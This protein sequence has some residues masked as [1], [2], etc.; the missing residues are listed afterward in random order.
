M[1]I[2][3]LKQ[4]HLTARKNKEQVKT[5]VLSTVIG[6]ASSKAVVKD[7]EKIVSDDLVSNTIKKFV[8]GIDE[9]LEIVQNNQQLLEERAILTGYLPT[10]LTEEKLTEIIRSAIDNG[11]DNMGSIM[12]LL[13]T[14]HPNA[15]DG[16]V[17]SRIANEL[18]KGNVK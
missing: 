10:S 4:D 17:A 11:S 13:K 12:G 6:E 8:K 1:L 9:T 18:L 15:Y 14:N 7:G 5:S 3:K 2:E 16:K